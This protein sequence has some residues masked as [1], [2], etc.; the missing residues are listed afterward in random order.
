M[1]PGH[2]H[3]ENHHHHHRKEPHDSHHE[4]GAHT[5]DV[6]GHQPAAVNGDPNRL[7]HWHFDSPFDRIALAAICDFSEEFS[8]TVAPFIN[9][10]L[11]HLPQAARPPPAFV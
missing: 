11:N 7:G 6:H 4:H 9:S 1:A 5:Y 3:G 2:D 8:A 10:G